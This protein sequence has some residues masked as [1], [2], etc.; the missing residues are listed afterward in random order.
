MADKDAMMQTLNT[1][2]SKIDKAID[3]YAP[4]AVKGMLSF[5]LQFLIFKSQLICSELIK[6]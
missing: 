6:I 2:T 5:A 3:Q 1:V 4:P